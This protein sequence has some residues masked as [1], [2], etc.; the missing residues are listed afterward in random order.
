[1]NGLHIRIG[2]LLAF[3]SVLSAASV[4]NTYSAVKPLHDTYVLGQTQFSPGSA[5]SMRVIVAKAVSLASSEPVPGA[6]VAIE[7]RAGDGKRT[8]VYEGATNQRGTLDASFRIPDLAEGSY[9]M[10]VRTQSEFGRD[11][12][13]RE[14]TLRRAAKILLTTDKPLYQPAQTMH[15]RALALNEGD[16]RPVA[17]EKLILEVEDSKGNK[18]FKKAGD[19]SKFGI[20][21]AD[22]VLAHEVNMGTY[23]VR[24]LLGKAQA[25]KT[26]EV[27][28][29]VLP[30][31]KV[32]VT[33]D[34]KFY[35]PGETA[36]GSVQSDYFFGKPVAG[37]KVTLKASTFD[38]K[39]ND[40]ATLDGQTDKNGRYEFELKLPEHFV[41][42]PLEKGDAL[43]KLEVKVKDTADHTETVTKTYNVAKDAI[44]LAVIPESGKVVPGV[45]NILY[46]FASY[47]DGEPAQAA[48]TLE[49]G[50]RT[51]KGSTDASG[52]VEFKLTPRG[53]EM[54]PPQLRRGRRFGPMPM[55]EGAPGLD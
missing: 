12:L 33:T 35:L 14:V 25:E 40:F 55:D 47:P 5:A 22:F 19:L 2:L 39:F 29:Y 11:E 27:K 53:E 52:I 32:E 8:A 51:L 24:A 6:K 4:V 34:K 50:E 16:L 48:V 1:M 15:I 31:F 54:R 17:A 23:K 38:V 3:V 37:G 30:K 41:G 21:S 44:R 13:E 26:V 43:L 45:E 18:V 9:T 42:Q 36:K 20:A 46:V 49:A 28:R 10:V 7:L